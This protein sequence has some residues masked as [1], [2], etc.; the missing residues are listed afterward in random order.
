MPAACQPPASELRGAPRPRPH[1]SISLHGPSPTCPP[2]APT[3][4]SVTGCNESGQMASL[5]HWGDSPLFPQPL[6]PV[7]PVQCPFCPTPYLASSDFFSPLET[8]PAVGAELPPGILTARPTMFPAEPISDGKCDRRP[9]PNQRH[10]HF[11]S[12]RLV[13]AVANHGLSSTCRC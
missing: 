12:P 9:R 1:L 11:L 5:Q 8:L 6:S 2:L 4:P 3:S 7:L 13:T 10:N